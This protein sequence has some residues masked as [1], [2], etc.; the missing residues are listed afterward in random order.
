MKGVNA[1]RGM[2]LHQAAPGAAAPIVQ[3]K[4]VPYSNAGGGFV[5]LG[6]ALCKT[7]AARGGMTPE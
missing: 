6:D 7:L 1:N 5:P 2:G 3:R 4:I